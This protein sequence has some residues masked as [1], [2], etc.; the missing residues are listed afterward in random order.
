MG[1]E[2][3]R[4]MAAWSVTRTGVCAAGVVAAVQ[5]LL[6]LTGNGAVLHGTLLDPDCYMHLQR[7]LGMMRDGRWHETL[8]PRINAPYGYAIHWTAVFDLLLAAGAAV[9]HALG[10]GL[11]QALLVWGSAI[12]PLLLVAALAVFAWGVKRRVSGPLFLWLT[13]LLFTQPQLSGAFI[14]GRPDHH[15]LV[16][17]L[18]LAQL[19][20]LYALFDGRAG[21]R[22]ALAAGVLAGLQLCTSVEGL[23]TILLVSAS[24]AAAWLFYGR[25]CLKA[26]WLYLGG[27]VA[28]VFLWLG[29]EDGRYLFQPA[30][31]RV[32]VVHLVA[33]GSGFLAFGVLA[34]VDSRG[35]L[36][37]KPL[38]IAAAVVAGVAA[39]ALT[40]AFYPDFF[41]GPWPHLDPAV[42][43]FHRQIAELQPLAPLSWHRLA[44][45]LAQMTAPVL[46]LPLVIARLRHQEDGPVMLL[47]LLGF[48]LF[49]ALAMF[50]MRWSGEVQAVMLLPWTLTTVAIMQSEISLLG[51]KLRSFALG[52]ALLLQLL[53]A[54][55]AQSGKLS[56]A[57]VTTHPANRCGWS[58]AAA[59]LHDSVKPGTIVMAPLWVGPEILWRSDLRVVAGPYEM[60]PA[61]A[62]TAAF[63]EGS[64][65]AA[66]AV[67]QSRRIGFAL[68]CRTDR[69]KGFGNELAAGR[70]PVWLKPV[71]FKGGPKEFALYR[72][73]D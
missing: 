23:L 40:G 32:S 16:L 9:L 68:V 8:D 55:L 70:V 52:G 50:Q 51:V 42:V 64:E 59:V 24:L 54:S 11:H 56:L 14:A 43:A 29:W 45:F 12:S 53:P 1:W 73:A 20:W 4:F 65:A 49:A 35:W 26:L 62:D 60:P 44:M 38:R 57:D 30:Y 61:L 25:H 37:R 63:F 17:G 71:P 21:W 33:L 10:L 67:V 58:Q 36:E 46:A 41:L 34:W 6:L 69:G 72:V 27:C 18:L 66:H 19:A 7:T 48:L 28:V 22:W 47:S 39:A 31:D 5:G 13:L 2:R 15:S 3:E